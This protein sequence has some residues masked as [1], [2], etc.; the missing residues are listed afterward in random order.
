M[1]FM[2]IPSTVPDCPCIPRLSQPIPMTKVQNMKL[3]ISAFQLRQ[4]DIMRVLH[5]LAALRRAHH[6]HQIL[7]PQIVKSARKH[8]RIHFGQNRRRRIKL[9]RQWTELDPF[10]CDQLPV[11]C[12]HHIRR[13]YGVLIP[14]KPFVFRSAIAVFVFCFIAKP[15]PI[16]AHP[17]GANSVFLR[18]GMTSS[19]PQ[20]ANTWLTL[21]VF[22]RRSQCEFLRNALGFGLNV[23]QERFQ[24]N[25]VRVD[26][27][28]HRL[29]DKVVGIEEP[30]VKSV[31]FI[32]IPKRS[33]TVGHVV[34]IGTV[35]GH[36]IKE[37]AVIVVGDGSRVCFQFLGVRLAASDDASES[38]RLLDFAP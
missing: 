5:I 36:K 24:N 6:R 8:I 22:F 12:M 35:I 7:M 33:T 29:I 4:I 10:R 16:S 17:L 2:E 23:K 28:E 26:E 37:D 30:F 34:F 1:S 25:H 19:N 38:A 13:T 15:T 18:H 20:I 31:R 3:E 11:L 14:Y 9:E 27:H 32:E 21:S